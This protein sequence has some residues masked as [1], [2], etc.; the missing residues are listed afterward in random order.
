MDVLPLVASLTV[1]AT[2][3]TTQG[4]TYLG[5]PDFYVST[6]KNIFVMIQAPYA[7]VKDD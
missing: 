4:I 3:M 7:F 1:D 5:D 6:D 2:V